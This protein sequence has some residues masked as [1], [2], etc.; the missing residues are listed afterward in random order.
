[1]QV[2]AHVRAGMVQRSRRLRLTRFHC[3]LIVRVS[4]MVRTIHEAHHQRPA[5][6]ARVQGMQGGAC[7]RGRQGKHSNHTHTRQTWQA[8]VNANGSNCQ[9]GQTQCSSQRC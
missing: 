3:A 2:Q 6:C 1:M 8:S 4:Q 7:V 5:E 9:L